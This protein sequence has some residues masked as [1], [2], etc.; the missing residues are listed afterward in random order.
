VTPH[1]TTDKPVKIARRVCG[2][3][4]TSEELRS[5]AVDYITDVVG[6]GNN[7]VTSAVVNVVQQRQTVRAPARR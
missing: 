6:S 5:C 1:A 4:D 3:A 7:P 2:L